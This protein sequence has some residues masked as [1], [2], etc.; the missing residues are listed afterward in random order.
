MLLPEVHTIS[1][2]PDVLKDTV[3]ERGSLHVGEEILITFVRDTDEVDGIIRIEGIERTT[4]ER[5]SWSQ[6]QPH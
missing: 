3:G 5:G 6:C 1:I 2:L 4:L